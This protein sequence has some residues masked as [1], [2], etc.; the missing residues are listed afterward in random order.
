L[1]DAPRALVW[2]VWTDAEHLAQWWGP[3][4]FTIPLCE[5]DLRIDGELRIHMQG[6]DGN[7]YPMTG[8][9]REIRQPEQLVFTGTP[10]DENG[11]P[12]FETLT[13]VTFTELV[14]QTRVDVKTRIVHTTPYAG[15]YLAGMNAGWMQN[16][17]RLATYLLNHALTLAA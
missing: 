11:D 15:L 6:P 12:L 3:H 17:E 2:E 16:L 10:L 9:Y 14:G 7:L 13:T 1:V 4:G 8:R 5:V